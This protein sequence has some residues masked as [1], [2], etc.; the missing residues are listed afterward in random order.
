MRYFYINEWR[1]NLHLRK[2]KQDACVPIREFTYQA[3][4]WIW[5]YVPFHS[6]LLQNR[7]DIYTLCGPLRENLEDVND[8]FYNNFIVLGDNAIQKFIVNAENV[9]GHLLSR[10][11]HCAW[12]WFCDR[13]Q[14]SSNSSA[15]D[16]VAA[17]MNNLKLYFE[18]PGRDS[19]L[20][21]S[22]DQKVSI[23]WPS[24]RDSL[25]QG[26]VFIR[27]KEIETLWNELARFVQD[28][29]E[30]YDL[31]RSGSGWWRDVVEGQFRP[32]AASEGMSG[33]VDG[34][35]ANVQLADL[36]TNIIAHIDDS[37]CGRIPEA[38]LL[39]V[40][41]YILKATNEL[42]QALDAQEPLRKASQQQGGQKQQNA[43]TSTLSDLGSNANKRKAALT[44]RW[45]ADVVAIL[46]LTFPTMT[47]ADF[48]QW[49][50]AWL[51][52][53][54]KACEQQ[55]DILVVEIGNQDA[56]KVLRRTPERRLRAETIKKK[57]AKI[58]LP[59][60]SEQAAS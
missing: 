51:A 43:D 44:M 53:W 35:V 17:A 52:K 36:A 24:V 42:A 1:E 12:E 26:Y 33:R 19:N 34:K 59:P 45:I 29:R 39:E 40:L 23:P 56:Q 3:Y 27:S 15:F 25:A 57:L 54:F 31:S 16:S 5:G 50:E 48:P 11:L 4:R 41:I 60:A 18:E 46:P 10:R 6:Q 49:I 38:R 37:R 13:V 21:R 58:Q 2:S 28:A 7:G 9:A 20:L 8:L 32:F 30:N 14:E 47:K 55:R 22:F